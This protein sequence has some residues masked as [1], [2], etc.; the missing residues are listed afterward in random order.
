MMYEIVRESITEYFGIS[1]TP[2]TVIGLIQWVFTA[3]V[4]MLIVISVIKMLFAL[5]RM[6]MDG[7]I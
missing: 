7:K 6:L 5:A 1:E 2:Q 3:T 4:C